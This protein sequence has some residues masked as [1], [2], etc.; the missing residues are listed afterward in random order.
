MKSSRDTPPPGT[1]NRRGQTAIEFIAVIVVVF[2]FV[3]FFLSF[4]ILLVVSEYMDYATF[5]AARTY[6]AGLSSE[7]YQ[8]NYARD[9]VFKAYTDK[10]EGIAR[11]FDIQFVQL[12]PS[13]EQSKGAV[14]SYDIDL[15]YLPPLF[16]TGND[17]P[18]STIRLQS[19]A[20][21]GRDPTFEECFGYFQ[22]FSSQFGLN[23][24]GLLGQMDDNG[25]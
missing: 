6:K 2:F 19:Q 23:L 7:A 25:C 24:D 1:D 14:A 13:D 5:M 11:N 9:S 4:A 21:L 17:R 3:F 12:D 10:I 18:L 22:R 20:F 15:F 16:V 8:Q